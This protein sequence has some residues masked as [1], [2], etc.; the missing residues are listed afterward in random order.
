MEPK[1][2]P[3]IQYHGV[4]IQFEGLNGALPLEKQHSGDILK[5]G[6][7][8]VKK[9]SLIMSLADK[10]RESMNLSEG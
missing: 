8:R 3:T 4:G 1:R 10:D 9:T 2:S 5:D 6:H 7:L